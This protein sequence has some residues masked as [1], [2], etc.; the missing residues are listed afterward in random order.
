[1]LDF[2]GRD[3]KAKDV[4]LYYADKLKASSLV[5]ILASKASVSNKEEALELSC[6]FWRMQDSAI[7]DR[8]NGIE[9]LGEADLQFWME[10]S[11]NIISGYLYS[12]GYEEQWEQASDE[13]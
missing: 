3:E 1:M 10:R 4:C 7:E 12:I 13:V 11:M 2:S 9:V 5:E 6:F 8:D